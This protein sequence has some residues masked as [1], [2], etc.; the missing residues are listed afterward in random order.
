[1]E[2]HVSSSG[3]WLYTDQQ[4]KRDGIPYLGRLVPYLS[5]S[6]KSNLQDKSWNYLPWAT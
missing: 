5:L 6:R 1:M 2:I 3:L 4:A